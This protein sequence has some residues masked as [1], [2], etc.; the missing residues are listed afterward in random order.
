MAAQFESDPEVFGAAQR[1]GGD[2]ATSVTRD[3]S[4]TGRLG[5]LDRI[6]RVAAT[7]FGASIAQIVLFR[8]GRI[9]RVAETG[10]T[11]RARSASDFVLAR[12]DASD[13]TVDAPDIRGDQHGGTRTGAVARLGSAAAASLRR[14]DGQAI[15][16][17]VIGDEDA[18]PP[19]DARARRV[20]A[21][22]AGVAAE[23]VCRDEEAIQAELERQAAD[24][25]AVEAAAARTRFLA[26]V[27]HELRTPLNAIAGFA[28]LLA[29]EMFGPHAQPQ[30]AEYSADIR[31]S[32]LRLA[33][34]ISRVLLY[35]GSD[36]TELRAEM[37]EVEIAP[38]ARRCARLAASQ[39]DGAATV[40]LMIAPD[41]PT[42]VRGDRTYL[43]QV[44]MEML[45][46]TVAVAPRGGRVALA[47]EPAADGGLDVIVKARR[48]IGR[49]AP[50]ALTRTPD[51]TRRAPAVGDD[52]GEASGFSLVR[53]LVA[54]HGGGLA[55]TDAPGG[56][57]KAVATFP[58]PA[59]TDSYTKG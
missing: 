46:E 7:H 5:A 52:V 17:L 26:A 1:A 11:Q 58:A 8:D 31:R 41:A 14:D 50:N 4:R 35:A 34:M 13:A 27:N 30:Y 19:L 23:V 32:A 56:A 51:L 59:P 45:L 36:F 10:A 37:S 53:Q 40:E 20:L 25:R 15:G 44:V 24:Q 54:L 29:E 2:P 12:L 28:E 21:D 57:L 55:L 47:L 9:I 22:L 39:L 49:R 48:A 6:V 43:T 3:G 33:T 18:R 16:A 42:V 38:L